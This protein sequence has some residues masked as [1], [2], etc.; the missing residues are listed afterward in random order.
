M[1]YRVLYIYY[2]CTYTRFIMKIIDRMPKRIYYIYCSPIPMLQTGIG[3]AGSPITNT[4]TL[5]P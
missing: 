1:Q 5:V 2:T 4:G 3:Y